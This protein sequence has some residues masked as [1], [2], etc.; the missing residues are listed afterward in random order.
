MPIQHVFQHLVSFFI[1][2]YYVIL[3]SEDKGIAELKKTL[4]TIPVANY[5]LLKHTLWLLN[6]ISKHKEKNHMGADNLAKVFGYHMFQVWG[7]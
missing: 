3:I 2:S 7:V 6:D 1:I 4:E 5:S